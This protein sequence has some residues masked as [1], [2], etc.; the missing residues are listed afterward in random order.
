[1]PPSKIWEFR[2]TEIASAGFSCT[3]QQILFWWLLGLLDLVCRLCNAL[4]D[5]PRVA[6]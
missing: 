5:V 6:V 3:I 2:T 1:M 4:I